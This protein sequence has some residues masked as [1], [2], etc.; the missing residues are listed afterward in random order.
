ME[1]PQH[2]G[3]CRYPHTAPRLPHHTHS[4][5]PPS[6]ALGSA[7]IYIHCL[8]THSTLLTSLRLKAPGQQPPSAHPQAGMRP[9]EPSPVGCR[10]NPPPQQHCPTAMLPHRAGRSLGSDGEPTPSTGRRASQ[11]LT[12]HLQHRRMQLVQDPLP[13]DLHTPHLS[14][15]SEPGASSFL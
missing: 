5:C 7:M 3:G 4:Y 14:H 1:S 11:E 13:K 10:S 2:Y 9:A 6:G 12:A 15:A 8:Q